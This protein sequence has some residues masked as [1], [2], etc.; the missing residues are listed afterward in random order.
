[1]GGSAW[2]RLEWFTAQLLPYQ[3]QQ[4][5]C[6]LVVLHALTSDAVPAV[7]RKT[8]LEQNRVM[9]DTIQRL[10]AE[11][12]DE[13]SVVRGNAQHLAYVFLSAI[14]GLAASTAF[15]GDEPVEFPDVASVLL[16]LRADRT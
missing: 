10:V 2:E 4:P 1:H 11:G 12:Q 6:S 16:M 13:G 9:F 7:L 15:V 8:V 5:E 3:Y 14:Y